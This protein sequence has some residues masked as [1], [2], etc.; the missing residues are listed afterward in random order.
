MKKLP[1]SM[2]RYFWDVDP[3]K[4]DVETKPE[5]VISRLID[6]GHT[7]AIKWMRQ[8]YRDEQIEKTLKLLRGVKRKSANYW[9]LMLGIDPKEVKC[10]QTPY[11]QTPFGG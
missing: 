5:Y 3:S 6:Y 9:S 7:T 10:L 1:K 4:L 8:Q 2:Y 11:R